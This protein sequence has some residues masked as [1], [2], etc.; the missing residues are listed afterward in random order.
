MTLKELKQKV[1]HEKLVSLDDFF[2]LLAF[3]LHQTKTFL[4]AHEEY[5]L[6]P[7]EEREIL[8]L[9]ERRAKHEP[10]AYLTTT[11]EFYGRDFFV[12]HRV[13]IP[14]P[15]TEHIIEKVITLSP[16]PQSIIDIGTG[17][18]AIIL[19]LAKELSEPQYFIGVDTSLDALTVATLNQQKLTDHKTLLFKSDLLSSIPERYFT[20]PL[21][22]IANLPYVPQQQYSESMPDVKNYEPPEALVSG[23][24]GLDH[25]RRLITELSIKNIPHFT[26][27]L[28][29]DA[30]QT[31]TLKTLFEEHFPSGH[32]SVFQDLA[33]YDRV[34]E[35]IQ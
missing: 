33:G 13:L 19:T 22:L 30:S 12:D 8:H 35:F 10:V 6:T 4:L 25:Y 16:A 17:S 14:R 34:I 21:V 3:I 7:N 5:L 32:F 23:V 18:G 26:L 24:D 15:E 29:I 31:S 2:V 11:K 1:L 27:F 9:L 20:Q 28:E